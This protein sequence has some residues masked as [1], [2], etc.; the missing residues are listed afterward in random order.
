MI[1]LADA[2]GH[3]QSALNQK[4]DYEAY[5]AAYPTAT[6]AGTPALAGWH[7]QALGD[8]AYLTNGGYGD[9]AGVLQS[10]DYAAAFAWGQANQDLGVNQYNLGAPGAPTTVPLTYTM[11]TTVPA[12]TNAGPTTPA[13]STT[14]G[15]GASVWD[16]VKSFFGDLQSVIGIVT[17]PQTYGANLGS[18]VSSVGAGVATGIQDIG[19][20]VGAGAQS[21]GSGLANAVGGI[22]QVLVWPVVIIGGIIAIDRISKA[23]GRR[24]RA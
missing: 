1:S 6:E 8:E 15:A 11:P 7:K 12:N 19:G 9:A 16:A 21:A 17:Q 24:R 20:G 4:R 5:L 23:A 2:Q 14:S 22:W 13:S 10:D 18:G 3:F